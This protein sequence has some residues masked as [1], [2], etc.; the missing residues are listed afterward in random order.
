MSSRGT[1]ESVDVPCSGNRLIDSLPSAPRNAVLNRCEAVE[2]AVGTV[3][4]EAGE[5]FEYVY[6]P[7]TGAISL[8]TQIASHKPFE[9]ESIG[10]RD[11]LGATLILNI[12]HAPQ[13]GIV[14]TPCRVL[15]IKARELQ[16]EIQNHPALFRT[17]QRYLF[18]VLTELLQTTACVRF[19]EVEKRLAHSLLLAHDNARADHL[20]LT[21]LL[22]A[23]MLG[24]QRGAVTIAAVKLQREGIIRYSRG[25]ISILDRQGLEGKSCECYAASLRNYS[26]MLF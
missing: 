20:H 18:F 10:F 2:L 16:A 3:L 26:N 5:S 1:G 25:N 21:H 17:L 19:H 13:R 22:L 24:V 4:C 11:M 12:S 6:F 23:D 9:T 14:N 8:V 15:R 7:I